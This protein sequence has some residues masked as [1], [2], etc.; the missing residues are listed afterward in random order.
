MRAARIHAVVQ[1]DGTQAVKSY[2]TV[3][4]IEHPVKVSCYII[5]GVPDMARIEADTELVLQRYSIYDRTYL[6]EAPPDL[7]A[8]ARHRLEQYRRMLLRCQH[9]IQKL[10]YI[11]DSL[12]CSL[13]DT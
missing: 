11:G 9:I 10:C 12:L 13:L 4:C 8:L 1:M 2:D 5:S 6:L 7:C 3:K